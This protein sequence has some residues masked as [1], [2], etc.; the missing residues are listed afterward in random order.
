MDPEETFLVELAGG[1]LH[2]A[3]WGDGP[4]T[5]L[6]VHGITA[7]SVGF[8]L[9][10]PALAEAGCTVLAP[11]LRGRGLS[12][13]LPGPSSMAQHADDLVAVLDATGA[14]RAVVL[15]HSMGG[16]V[17]TAFAHRHP[18]RLVHLVLLDG[19]PA[20]SGELPPDVDVEAVLTA[21]VGP[22]VQR[23]HMTWPTLEDYHG[24]WRAHPALQAGVPD[25]VVR[26]YADHDAVQGDDGLWRSRVSEARVLE[27]ARDTLVNPEVRHGVQR[28]TRP[29]HFVYAE[30]GMLDGPVGLYPPETVAQVHADQP[31][32]TPVLVPDVNH[33]TIGLSPHGA[34]AV[35][36]VVAGLA[37]TLER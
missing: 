34:A 35:A 31:L 6:A 36:A 23:L 24:F 11:D 29:F 25:E 37:D 9:L 22:S 13:A 19:G 10:G 32:M 28:L 33:F 16:F 7:S 17:A 30:R 3:R 27:D 18:E 1:A 5:V 12:A 2:V 14:A 15:G 4:V 21:I 20:L 8:C 26:A